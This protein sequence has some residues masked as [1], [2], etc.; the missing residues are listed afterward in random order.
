CARGVVR[1]DSAGRSFLALLH[2]GQEGL[3]ASRFAEY[4]SLGQMTEDEEQVAPAAWERFVVDAAVIGGL[5]RWEKRLAGLREEFHRRYQAA[6]EEESRASLERKIVSLEALSR[7]AL[8][9]LT[10]L[11]M[12]PARISWGEWISA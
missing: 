7:F 3:S 9:I 8:P 4:L 2:C 11:S 1:P 6:R 12:L 10:R 5:P